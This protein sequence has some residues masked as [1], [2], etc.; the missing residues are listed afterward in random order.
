MTRKSKNTN[1]NSTTACPEEEVN[2]PERFG[3]RDGDSA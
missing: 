3:S 2:S 1:V